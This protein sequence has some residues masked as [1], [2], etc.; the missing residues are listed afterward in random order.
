MKLEI[1]KLLP[2]KQAVLQQAAEVACRRYSPQTLGF[3]KEEAVDAQSMLAVQKV[4]E[5]QGIAYQVYAVS[6]KPAA[7]PLR[8]IRKI[9]NIKFQKHEA[10]EAL[11]AATV[12]AEAIQGNTNPLNISKSNNPKEHE[13]PHMIAPAPA[14]ATE[15]VRAS[16]PDRAHRQDHEHETRTRN[17]HQIM[18]TLKD[19]SYWPNMWNDVCHHV[20]SCHQCQIQSTRKVEVP[21]TVSMPS[22]IFSKIHLDVM[23]MPKVRGFRYIIA[24]RDDLS[25]AA[26]GRALRHSNAKTTA[27]FIWEEIFCRYG[28]VG[29]IVTDN[30]SELQAAVTLLMD[31]Y[32]ILHI[33]I[34][35]YNS[36]ANGVV[37][38]GHFTIREAI[39]KA[40]EGATK[41]WPDF[42]PHAFFADKVTVRRATGYSPFYLLHGVHSVLP[43]D[44][45]E[46]SF[47]IIN[48]QNMTSEDLSAARI[49][50]LQKKPED[51]ERAAATLRKNRL[52]SKKQFEK[53]SRTRLCHDSYEQGTLV[54]VRNSGIEKSMDRK[55]KPRYLGPYR[56]IRRTKGGVYALEELDGAQWKSRIAASRIMP[57]I[58]RGDPRLCYLADDLEIILHQFPPQKMQAQQM[59]KIENSAECNWGQLRLEV[60]PGCHAPNP[61][62][63][64][65]VKNKQDNPSRA[66]RTNKC[67]HADKG[68]ASSVGVYTAIRQME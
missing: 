49:R 39:M 43:F 20:H 15:L 37:E 30:G 13:G 63:T 2:I 45:A 16:E 12:S 65:F 59:K 64:C 41:K 6:C 53:R 67:K 61:F 5:Q 19:R 24:A 21:L 54:L 3:L 18:Q 52:R 7:L 68:P 60:P 55:S 58:S 9:W 38:R 8:E 22:T 10:P 51:L 42:V 28:A 40:C 14:H 27:Q 23:F 66:R 36:K 44:L 50:Q 62:G 25:G 1:F 33:K 26:E 35:A 29:H 48:Q 47:I 31:R 34:S 11:Q 32:K 57:Y 17:V 56:V 4:P 46:A